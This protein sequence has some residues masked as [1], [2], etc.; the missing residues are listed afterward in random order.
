MLDH[1]TG[2]AMER[3]ENTTIGA[4]GSLNP[5]N[6]LIRDWWQR[7]YVIIARANSVLKGSEPYLDILKGNSKQYLA[8]A[9]VLRA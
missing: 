1:W 2:L 6:T 7:L 8:E 9:R 4:G 5:D 3:T